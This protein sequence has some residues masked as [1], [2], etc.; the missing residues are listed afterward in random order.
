MK[1]NPY[2]KPPSVAWVVFPV[3]GIIVIA[4]PISVIISANVV[5]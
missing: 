1:K 2:R 5:H 3:F 4:M